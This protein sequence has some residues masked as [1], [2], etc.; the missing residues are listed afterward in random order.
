MDSRKLLLIVTDKGKRN[1]LLSIVAF[2]I[3]ISACAVIFTSFA[4]NV[5]KGKNMIIDPGHGG[6]DPGTN[7]GKTFFEKDINLQIS[8]KLCRDLESYQVVTSMTRNDDRSLDNQISANTSR[9][10]KDLMARVEHFNSGTY[11][12]FISVHV[13]RS[14]NPRSMGP[15]V[16]YSPD[17][18]ESKYLA[19]C[20]QQRF[21]AHIKK[22]LG[23]ETER[24]PV[25]SSFYV[26]KNSRIPGVIVETGFI[27]NAEEKKLLAEESYQAKLSKSICLG[28][29]DYFQNIEKV[30]TEGFDADELDEEDSVPFN[31]TNE[32]R[33][34][35]YTN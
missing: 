1:M 25:K 16:L 17:N 2:C 29:Q 23:K 30:K 26:L 3:I 34:V 24:K 31:I 12:L 15:M 33:L 18:F 11:D 4:D 7:D 13:N 5:L 20:L 9:H 35:E 14:S 19:Y 10:Q 28:I 32:I 6:I 8:Q 27:S 21:N 22:V